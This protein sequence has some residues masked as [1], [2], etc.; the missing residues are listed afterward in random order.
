MTSKTS[1]L[2]PCL[3]I[4]TAV[5]MGPPDSWHDISPLERFRG[6]ILIVFYPV[7]RLLEH[8]TLA[9]VM[10]SKTDIIRSVRVRS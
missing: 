10:G 7:G 9:A 8:E 2:V 4:L 1:L 5:A 6:G 3:A